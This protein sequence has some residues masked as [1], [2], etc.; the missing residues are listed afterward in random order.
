MEVLTDDDVA[1]LLNIGEGQGLEFKRNVSSS[2]AREM[3]AFANSEGGRIIFGIDDKNRVAG[4]EDVNRAVSAIQSTA[5]NCDPF[6]SVNVSHI[7]YAEKLL[8]VAEVPV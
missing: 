8:V 2:V 5:R 7:K 6:I 1:I 3:V 4:I